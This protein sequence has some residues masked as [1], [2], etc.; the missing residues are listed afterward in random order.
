MVKN[1]ESF[2]MAFVTFSRDR[3]PFKMI[4]N[5]QFICISLRQ[6]IFIIIFQNLNSQM[7]KESSTFKRRKSIIKKSSTHVE[8][9]TFS[10]KIL[11]ASKN[12]KTP[13]VGGIPSTNDQLSPLLPEVNISN[14]NRSFCCN[15]S[16]LSQ[17][18]E[19]LE[20][21]NI[22]NCFVLLSN[23]EFEKAKADAEAG[24]HIRRRGKNA[25]LV[26]KR[27]EV[28]CFRKFFYNFYSVQVQVTLT[29]PLADYQF[30]ITY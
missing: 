27:T 15:N 19:A 28:V 12:Q 30:F 24:L 18:M 5:I 1:G 29:S 23:N 8:L 20:N 21:V 6:F 13:N 10:A 17:D 7:M 9:S 3:A 22:F 26:T 25:I 16:I 14:F 4:L 2:D 11:K